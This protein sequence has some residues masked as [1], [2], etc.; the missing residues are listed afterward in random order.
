MKKM[1]PNT[2]I[3]GFNIKV[4]TNLI[5]LII[6]LKQSFSMYNIGGKILT[7]TIINK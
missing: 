5:G 1:I 4:K 7:I 2:Y 6:G 3:I